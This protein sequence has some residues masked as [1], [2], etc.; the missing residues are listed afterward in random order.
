MSGHPGGAIKPV[1]SLEMADFRL[2]HNATSAL[3]MSANCDSGALLGS[4][5]AV[6]SFS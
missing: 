3:M 5:P 1:F 2:A 6:S 4:Q